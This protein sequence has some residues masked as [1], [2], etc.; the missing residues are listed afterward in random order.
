MSGR[1]RP[2]GLR[3]A[4]HRAPSIPVIRRKPAP[5]PHTPA[6]LILSILIRRSVRLVLRTAVLMAPARRPA[7]GLNVPDPAIPAA[8][9]S[10]VPVIRLQRDRFG[11]AAPG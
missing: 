4:Y 2:V 3:P 10:A 9:L 11:T 8:I 5:V 1:A 7:M 6:R